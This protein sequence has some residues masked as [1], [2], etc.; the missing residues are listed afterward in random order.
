MRYRPETIRA[1]VLDAVYPLQANFHVDVFGTYNQAFGR[2]SAACAADTTCNAAYPDLPESFA[3][4]VERLNAEAAVLPILNLE[5]G[6]PVDYLP[7]TGIDVAVI[8]FQLMYITPVLPVLPAVIGE[9]DQGNYLP[10]ASLASALFSDQVP[11][12]VP[13]VSQGMQV[14]V[15][16]NEDVTFASAREFVSA[17]DRNRPQAGLAFSPLFNEAILEVC[18]AWGLRPL[19][20]AEN[21]AVRSDVPALLISGE[22]DPIT[23]PAFAREAARTL[24]R[25][26]ELL[27]PRGGHTAGVTSPCGRATMVRFFDAPEQRPDAGC[28]A[29]EAPAPFVVVP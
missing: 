19:S 13:I 6:E 26:T 7:F 16:C 29:Q 5:T 3:R 2:L 28:L 21:Q 24:S 8:V 9:A 15:Q 14:A 22:L 4:V 1:A 12:D 11:R 25:S 20:A 10:L 27:I 17:R 18:A 23:P